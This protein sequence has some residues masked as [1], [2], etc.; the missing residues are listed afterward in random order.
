MKRFAAL[1][2]S[3]LLAVLMIGSVAFAEDAAPEEEAE[4]VLAVEE[5]ADTEDSDIPFS[6]DGEAIIGDYSVIEIPSNQVAVDDY[7]VDSYIDNI[8]QYAMTTEQVTEGTV[9]EGDLVN[10]DFSGVLEGE[11]EPFDGGTAEGYDITIGSGMFIPGFEEQIAGHSVGETF[12]I[13][14]TFPE[15]YTEELAGKN[16]VFTITVN[17]KTVSNV[18]E[19][20]DEFVQEFS[21][22]NMDEQFNTVEELKDYTRE[23]L[24]K[25]RLSDA[26]F[27]S[28]LDKI[29]VISYPKDTYEIAKAYSME[30]LEYYVY[31]YAMMG[32]EGY[33]AD[34]I[35]QMNG[36]ASAEDYCNEYAQ[37]DMQTIMLIDAICKDKGIECTDEELDQYVADVMAAN[38]YDTMYTVEEFKEVN[39][40]GWLLFARYNLLLSKVLEALEENVVL[41]EAVMTYYDYQTANIDDP[42]NV[43]VYVQATQSWWEDKISVYAADEMGGYFIYNMACSEEDAEKLVPGTKIHVSGYKAEWSG[44]IEIADAEFEFINDGYTYIAPAL[45]VT[46]LLGQEELVNYMNRFVFFNGL[47]VEPSTDADGNE[48]AFLYNWDGSGTQGDDL[49]FNVSLNGET[50]TFTVES[51]LCDKDTDVYKAVEAL[52]VGDVVD[53]EGFLYWYNGANPHITSVTVK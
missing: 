30:S 46:D 12:D 13:T 21:A 36:F 39:G 49:Y 7:D 52:N 2:L 15:E 44:E 17:Y 34:M 42:V 10:I 27:S 14:V 6:E 22:A 35:A 25:N 3:M 40:E 24:Y 38:G 33:D 31:Y 19:L 51:Y 28:I 48:A 45:D 43:D 5:T 8:L 32:L 37:S 26:I 9:E 23:Y 16:A 41:T 20:T 50:F 29:E 1:L 47:T 4:E 18:P 11:E 53:L